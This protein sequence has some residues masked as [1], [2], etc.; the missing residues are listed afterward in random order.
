MNKDITLLANN[1]HGVQKVQGISPPL[2][3]PF[4]GSSAPKY[5]L[6]RYAEGVILNGAPESPNETR[7]QL[8]KY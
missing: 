1:Q 7:L 6:M 2:P 8:Y 4:S 3:S 5:S